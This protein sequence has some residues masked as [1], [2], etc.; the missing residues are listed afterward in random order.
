MI[1]INFL[2]LFTVE[3]LNQYYPDGLC[4][5]FVITPSART[6]SV[7]SGYNLVAR[8]YGN[9]LYVGI[10]V[11]NITGTPV[12]LPDEGTQ[13]VFFMKCINSLFFNFT[14]SPAGIAGNL[15]Y[16]TNNNNN[17]LVSGPSFLTATIPQYVSANS[18]HIGD[19]VVSGGTV[20]EAAK[21]NP[22][23]DFTNFTN[24]INAGTNRYVTGADVKHSQKDPA[25]RAADPDDLSHYIPGAD[26]AELLNA[27]DICVVL[28]IVND[29]TLP[30]GYNLLT[31]GKA[32]V[33]PAP[34]KLFTICF[35]NRALKWTYVLLP[36]SSGTIAQTDPGTGTPAFPGATVPPN[37][38]ISAYPLR[39]NSVPQT[40]AFQLTTSY[41]QTVKP[42]PQASPVI[43]RQDKTSQELYS[44]IYLNY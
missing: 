40:Y 4:N 39:F 17:S 22:G 14:K 41:G 7:M 3:I 5:D 37:R 44:E 31:G 15:L 16:F 1:N 6:A 30:N 43:I 13:L 25:Q 11:D 28:N 29:S 42:L 20:F 26:Y 2:R 38:F 32:T 10:P 19:L 33:P 27:T 23:T 35:L 12:F 9:R 24:W 18:Y 36:L 34:P 21:E 8:Q